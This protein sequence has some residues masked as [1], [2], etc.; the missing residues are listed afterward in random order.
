M[1]ME[2][3]SIPS[4]IARYPQYGS[5]LAE[6]LPLAQNAHRSPGASKLPAVEAEI[7]AVA[8][9]F[10]QP[11][12]KRRVSF[13]QWLL[14]L[15]EQT[16]L[17]PLPRMSVASWVLVGALLVGLISGGGVGVAYAA[18]GANP[19]EPFYGFDRAAE[20]IQMAL[21]FGAQAKAN[22]GLLLAQERLA[23]VHSLTEQGAPLRNIY[24]ALIDYENQLE[25]V[26]QHVAQNQG[27]QNEFETHELGLALA[28]LVSNEA[29][30]VSWVA[31]NVTAPNAA[32]VAQTQSASGGFPNI[33]RNKSPLTAGDQNQGEG[34]QFGVENAPGI[35]QSRSNPGLA[36]GSLSLEDRLVA[37]EA[38][39]QKIQTQQNLGQVQ[40][41]KITLEK[42]E[43]QVHLLAQI[44][45]ELSQDEARQEALATLISTAQ[46]RHAQ[47]LA[48]LV[49][50]L[51]AQAQAGIQRALQ[52]ASAQPGQGG[53]PENVPGQ[54]NPGGGPPEDNPG[55]GNPGGGPPEDNPGQG[56]GPH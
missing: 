28:E 32:L 34:H 46:S 7:P 42:Y 21:T 19:G 38:L 30:E 27:V 20:S 11:H 6:L 29:S 14:F 45:A 48:Q 3:T 37:L 39:R 52:A 10:G 5:E 31:E 13:L 25:W 2:Q 54:G 55:Q 49:E 1:I 56:K 41:A 15:F 4:L 17:R 18:D 36:L 35:G 12:P 9:P 43:N 51:P 33:G 16:Q 26:S 24:R 8:N 22:F 47:V 44:M 50:Q 40:A 23:E 53:P